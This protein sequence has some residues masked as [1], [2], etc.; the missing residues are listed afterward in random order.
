MALYDYAFYN[1]E[2]LGNES[3]IIS[4]VRGDLRGL[5]KFQETFEVLLYDEFSQV[6]RFVEKR[7]IDAVYFQKAGYDDGKLVSNAR[8]LVHAVFQSYEP[9]GEVYAYISS[10]LAH[11]MTG[12][13]H[14]FVPYMVRL[15][16]SEDD[17][18]RQLNIP[19]DAV[20]F[21]R[22]GGRDQF[23]IPYVHRVVQ[24]VA[25]ARHDLYFLFMNTD[26]FCEPRANIIHLNPTWD[27]A[28]KTAFI[29]TCDAMLHARVQGETFGLAIAEFL[30]K[31]KPVIASMDGVDQNHVEMLGDRGL[32]YREPVEVFD[33]L[34][35]FTK[36]DN[37]GQYRELVAEFSPRRVMQKFEEVFLNARPA[38]ENVQNY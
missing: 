37:N 36:T 9:H 10:W 38:N 14:P 11:K 31:D 26:R 19:P 29:N 24:E 3:V 25:R 6:E 15:P 30:L 23:N 5:A 20:V 33:L 2:V 1:R 7:E 18:R 8:N 27:P 28:A 32:F 4:D 12:G 34:T 21:G 35:G 22:H 13:R 17:F 16:E